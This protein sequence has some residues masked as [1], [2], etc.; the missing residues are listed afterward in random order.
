M[1]LEMGKDTYED[2]CG[3]HVMGGGSRE[4]AMALHSW[5]VS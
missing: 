4:E 2:F 1:F 5:R 3:T